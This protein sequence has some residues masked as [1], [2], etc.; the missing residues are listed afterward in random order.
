MANIIRD[1]HLLVTL[2]QK[3]KI[4]ELQQTQVDAREAHIGD[5]ESENMHLQSEIDLANGDRDELDRQLMDSNSQIFLKDAEIQ[6]QKDLVAKEK[7][8]KEKLEVHIEE[9]IAQLDEK[10]N[11]L[12]AAQSKLDEKKDQL[13]AA[14]SK[15]DEK[16]N[17]LALAQSQSAELK[18]QKEKLEVRIGEVIAELDEKKDQL[19]A[20][21]SKLVDHEDH[22]AAAQSQLIELKSQLAQKQAELVDDGS[23]SEM[24]NLIA[25]LETE[26]KRSAEEFKRC[27]S[28]L[29]E[30]TKAFNKLSQEKQAWF[31]SLYRP[32]GTANVLPRPEFP[33]LKTY[34][35]LKRMSVPEARKYIQ[36]HEAEDRALFDEYYAL[37]RL[38]NQSGVSR[39][40]KAIIGSNKS[41]I[42]LR[43]KKIEALTNA[44]K[45]S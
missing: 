7:A 34:A 45:A 41:M 10:R 15:L 35:E 24:K 27:D 5:I 8:E 28:K 6:E 19:D 14:H 3:E 21:Q 2:Q 42:S 29:K 26:V 43:R 12:N 25:N 36:N 9:V 31:A 22:L 37:Q 1:Y 17:Q 40:D 33:R 20:A 16:K 11:E 44:Y 30:M 23:A 32:S 38:E 4:F 18:S 39:A 13:D